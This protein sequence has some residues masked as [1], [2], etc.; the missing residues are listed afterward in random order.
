M[1][2]KGKIKILLEL[3]EGTFGIR[4]AKKVFCVLLLIFGVDKKEIIEK[5]GISRFSVKKYDEFLQSGNIRQLFA[6]NTYRRKSE[7]EDY[8]SEIMA[9]LDKTPAR[10]PREA[11]VIIERVSGLKRKFAA[12]DEV[13]KKNGYKPLKV[14]FLP[15]KADV[16]A[17]HD[18]IESTLK[19]EIK[20]ARKGKTH[21]FF[22]DASH[23]VM[24]GFVGHLWSKVR[25]FV[26]TSSG[27][28]RYNVL[29]A[30]NFVIVILLVKE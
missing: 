4:F 24:G 14:G 28:S 16:A 19:P 21:L 18:F 3:V 30:L 17:Q 26:K 11:A 7:M 15:A 2:D 29:G 25:S 10:T 22:V 9:E 13:F 6:D 5:L 12:S 1:D 27:R 20:R 23:F 8:R